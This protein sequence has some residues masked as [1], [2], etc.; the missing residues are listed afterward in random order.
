MLDAA[1]TM[2]MGSKKKKYLHLHS[3]SV[4]LM[5]DPSGKE[6]EPLKIF[7]GKAVANLL[8]PTGSHQT[9]LVSFFFELF[10]P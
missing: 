2:L 4:N 9:S 5:A 10:F 8:P 7:A 1:I 3:S 6:D